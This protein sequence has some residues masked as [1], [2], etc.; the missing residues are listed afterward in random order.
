MSKFPSFTKTWHHSPSTEL[1]PL[2]P[3]LSAKTKTVLVTGGGSGIGKA[4][5]IAF[6]QAKARAV[7]IT[8]RTQSSLDTAKIE[9]EQA[10]KAENNKDFECLALRVDV[11][12]SKATDDAFFLATQKFGR[13]DVLIS[14][15]GYL[16]QHLPIVD[17]DLEDY[18]QSYE[19]NV[20]GALIVT[21]A[22]VKTHPH[23]KVPTA[24]SEH[25]SSP[26]PVIVNISTGAAHVAPSI[27]PSFSAYATSK[28]AALQIFSF[29]QNEHRDSLSVFN[30]QP[31]EIQTAMAKKGH[32]D[33]AKDDVRLPAHWCVWLAAKAETDAAFL[34]GRLAWA[35]WDLK[36]FL[37]R[38]EEVEKDDL[39]TIELKGWGKEFVEH[40]VD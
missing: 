11:T 16:D 35:N 26:K 6:A 19:I 15:A 24:G 12:D 21:K 5:A 37:A 29:L 1:S 28:L 38:K 17:S 36:E 13:I 20:K 39:L 23:L 9:I 30:L 27:L 7:I 22:F 3:A 34:K 31:G 18:W 14:N 4:T 33:L 32:R 25:S 40:Y 8:G 2:D 10:A